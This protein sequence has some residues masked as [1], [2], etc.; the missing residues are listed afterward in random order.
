MVEQEKPQI[1]R[2]RKDRRRNDRRKPEYYCIQCGGEL[3]YYIPEKLSDKEYFWCEVCQQM[4]ILVS[5][6]MKI[7][8][9]AKVKK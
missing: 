2:R 5:Q 8:Y 1:E 4:F 3:M 9:L 7:P 6:H